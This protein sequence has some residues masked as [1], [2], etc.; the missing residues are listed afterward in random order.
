ML[1]CKPLLLLTAL[2]LSP[3][4]VESQETGFHIPY[5]E[6][7]SEDEK[8]AGLSE[9][10][11]E[12]KYNFAN[13]DLVPDLDWDKTYLQYLPRVR[14]TKSTAEYYQVLVEL[15]ARLHDGHTNVYP[16][17]ELAKN[18]GKPLLQSAMIEGKLVVVRAA[19]TQ[20]KPGTE[21]I[22]IDDVPAREYA[23]S[24]VAPYVSAST[25]QDLE[26][27]TYSVELLFGPLLSPVKLTFRQGEASFSR[28]LARVSPE[29]YHKWSNQEPMVYRP[30]KIAYVA[31]NSFGDNKAVDEFLQKFDEISQADSLIL[32]LRDNGGGS[33]DEG[34]RVLSCLTDKPYQGS[35]WQT[36]EYRPA[37]RA[38]GRPEGR[39]APP[40]EVFQP[41][42]KHHFAKP[43]AVLIGPRTFSAAED[44]TVAFS[45]MKR[46]R[47]IGEATGGSSGQPLFINL[48]GGGT[49]RICSK[50]DTFADGREFIGKGIQPDKIVPPTL[51]DLAADR[52]AVLLEAE[53]ELKASSQNESEDDDNVRPPV[54]ESDIQI[55]RIALRLLGTS[56]KWNQHDTRDCPSNAKTFSLYC[57]LEKASM[58][59]N[60]KFEHRSAV[61]QEARFLIAEA[62]PGRRY[63]H[64]L[65]GYNNDPKTRFSDIRNLLRRLETRL[66]GRLAA[67]KKGAALVP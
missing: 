27:R 44:F 45:Q 55:A 3:L 57:V 48:P 40:V 4:Q 25:P 33:S 19:D 23:A 32:D 41:S 39:Y 30:G 2:L 6:N 31:L 26:R 46:G 42:P 36:R 17:D 9:F 52:D 50:R 58:Q 67:Q 49:A 53:A 22:A 38:W 24:R 54:K 10:W 51:A 64:R 59:V 8:V 29:V 37:F 12:V 16:P 61:M 13:F 47:L 28:S 14:Q 65:M 34:Y 43:V 60:G 63:E 11:S 18:E 66:R 7:L 5:R 62:A 20:L 21:I 15:G 56:A 35:R 1:K